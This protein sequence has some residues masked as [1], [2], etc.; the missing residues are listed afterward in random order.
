M[1]HSFLSNPIA[2]PEYLRRYQDDTCTAVVDAW[3]SGKRFVCV[4]APTG[5]GKTEI[6]KSLL[7]QAQ[8]PAAVVHTKV[9]R[10][11]TEKRVPRAL[12]CTVQSLL[13]DS[14]RAESRR[15]RIG[16]CDMVFGDEIHHWASEDWRLARDV[17]SSAACFGATATP[18]RADG[19]PLGDICDHLV[20][21]AQYSD[22]LRD[23]YLCPCDIDK[24]AMSRAQMKRL[25]VK[26]DPVKAY[27]QNG[28]RDDG[29]YR[30]AIL[31]APTIAVC[32]E[33]VD[34]LNAAGLR[35]AVVSCDT[36]EKERQNDEGTGIFDLYARGELDVLASPMALAE[37]FDAAR[38]EV[39]ILGRLAQHL[40]T[41]LQM[42]G[43]VLRP[44]GQR[45]I[46]DMV[47]FWGKR[48]ITL[49]P[50]ALIPKVRSLLIDCSDAASVHG[51][52]TDDRR[53][54]LDGKG[55]EA[56]EEDVDDE[57]EE[58][59][60][61][62]PP[63]AEEL[64]EMEFSRVRQQLTDTISELQARAKERGYRDAWVYHRIK[65]RFGIELP[66]IYASKYASVCPC[67]RHRVQKEEQ[68]YWL[69]PGN[70]HDKSRSFHPDCYIQS[71]PRDVLELV[72]ARQ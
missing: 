3:R 42:C 22:L 19:T 36:S 65:E 69:P 9:L 50:S 51:N 20:V 27:L 56:I 35:A 52:P 24:P 15:Q 17:V 48:G 28:K 7:L 31:F 38:A 62:E 21:S 54:S 70:G 10:Q 43:R 2:F 61:T 67:C 8:D 40:G 44:Y 29:S 71:L 68:I 25:K 45:Q 59:T 47:A 55:I 58:K 33:H 13:P 41:Y 66:R 30:P 60:P 57:E 5:A 72:R 53:Y 16:R 23:R 46:D 63:T 14:S 26:P 6:A 12:T 4:V 32:Q 49:H 34:K 11:Q 1:Q 39:C 37:G 18:Q 64:I